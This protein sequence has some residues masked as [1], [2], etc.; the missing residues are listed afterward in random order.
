MPRCFVTPLKR[1]ICSFAPTCLLYQG[2]I[3]I[4]IHNDYIHCITFVFALSLDLVQ[5]CLFDAW[6]K[7]Q[8][9]IRTFVHC[10]ADYQNGNNGEVILP[11]AST[12]LYYAQIKSTFFKEGC[13]QR[14]RESK[15]SD[16]TT[17]SNTTPVITGMMWTEGVG[18]LVLLWQFTPQMNI[19]VSV[20][21]CTLVYLWKYPRG[22]LPKHQ[23]ASTSVRKLCLNVS[24]IYCFAVSSVNVQS[25]SV[26]AM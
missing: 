24:D 1:N 13:A 11:V 4:K 2:H 26:G 23:T 9:N 6:V 22:V 17:G 10:V 7:P 20:F 25:L 12:C 15:I 3:Y 16:V 19:S 5:S 14:N 8:H 21:V 18:L